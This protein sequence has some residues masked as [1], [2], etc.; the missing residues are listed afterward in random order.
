[1]FVNI[2][3]SEKYMENQM[4]SLKRFKQ[5]LNI[6]LL[7]KPKRSHFDLLFLRYINFGKGNLPYLSDYLSQ[8][9][10]SDFY[11]KFPKTKQFFSSGS[12]DFNIRALYHILFNS[13][14]VKCGEMVN[15]LAFGCF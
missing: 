1:M 14:N 5:C 12:P 7:T 4:E 2:S 6:S 10:M 8:C 13:I 9:F 11:D 3:V 15:S